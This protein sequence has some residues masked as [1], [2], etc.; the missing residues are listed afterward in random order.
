MDRESS[1]LHGMIIC[2]R[3]SIVGGTS[4]ASKIQN[5]LGW[6][7]D[8]ATALC[9]LMILETRLRRASVIGLRI[10]R[11][12]SRLDIVEQM[13]QW[14]FEELGLQIQNVRGVII[15]APLSSA[16]PRA[17]M[18]EEILDARKSN[19]SRFSVILGCDRCP[20]LNKAVLW[21]FT[22]FDVFGRW[23][24][25]SLPR[26]RSEGRTT[27]SKTVARVVQDGCCWCLHFFF[28]RCQARFFSTDGLRA[29][30]GKT[31]TCPREAI[32]AGASA[33]E[34]FGDLF[35]TKNNRLGFITAADVDRRH[36][37]TVSTSSHAANSEPR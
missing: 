34:H 13:R 25:N 22:N 32:L 3:A 17:S 7:C 35:I 5:F 26:Q 37:T 9:L 19:E 28:L 24:L 11:R 4:F 15:A 6:L 1:W 8:L 33:D 29:P 18:C 2:H 31:K 12:V 21:M 16:E 27:T 36:F 14:V 23:Q 20:E 30:R 10:W